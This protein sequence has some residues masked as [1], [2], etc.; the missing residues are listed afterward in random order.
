MFYQHDSG[1]ALSYKNDNGL[2]E[3]VG[4]SSWGYYCAD[5]DPGVYVRVSYYNQWLYDET[6]GRWPLWG[7]EKS[8]TL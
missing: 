2:F 4:I 7:R 3:A 1:G 6:E 8:T 5:G